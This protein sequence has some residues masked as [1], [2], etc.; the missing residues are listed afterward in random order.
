MADSWGEYFSGTP[1][2]MAADEVR[3][4]QEY[5][6][7]TGSPLYQ[8][9]RS[10]RDRPMELDGRM[11]D[12]RELRMAAVADTIMPNPETDFGGDMGAAGQKALDAAW[13]AYQ[14]VFEAGM[15]PRDTLIKS[16]QAFNQ[17]E[18]MLAASLLARAPLSVL[19]PPAAAGTPDSPDDWRKDAEKLGVGPG[20][21][22]AI[23]LF[24]DP[25]TYM[26]IP[27]Q[28][29]AAS[30]L[31]RMAGPAMR[32]TRVFDEAGDMIRQLKAAGQ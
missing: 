2:Q 15:R 1:E 23:D 7:I 26:P 18:P 28:F 10:R 30:K 32:S 5:E 25:E 20:N 6:R 4:R 11:Y 22:M 17:S 9:M 19:Y 14:Y 8:A 31:G 24:T 13:P 29:H 12:P 27:I 16:A 3:R 21:I